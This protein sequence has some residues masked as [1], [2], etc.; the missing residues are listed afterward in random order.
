MLKEP[1]VQL[2]QANVADLMFNTKNEIYDSIL[3]DLDNGPIP[4]TDNNNYF[5]YSVSGI[6]KIKSLLKDKGRLVI[7][8]AG[9][10]Y[11]FENKFN[12]HSIK[13]KKNPARIHDNAKKARHMLYVFD[14]VSS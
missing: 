2:E 3:L 11:N 4:M 8:S 9:S 5:L 6:K 14:R 12:N 13:F 10:D 7:W 1:R